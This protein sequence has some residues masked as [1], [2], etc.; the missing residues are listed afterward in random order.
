MKKLLL[1]SLLLCSILS[2][3]SQTVKRSND[4][5]PQVTEKFYVQKANKKIREGEYTASYNK[6]GL[7]AQGSYE[8][9]YRTG[10]WEFYNNK[11][12]H[13]QTY[14]YDTNTMT[15]RD[16]TGKKGMKYYFSQDIVKGDTVRNPIPIGGYYFVIVPLVFYHPELSDMIRKTYPNIEKVECT[17]ILTISPEGLLAKHQ[18]MITVNGK[19]QFYNLSDLN[20]EDEYKKFV[21]GMINGKPV[22]SKITTTTLLSFFGNMVYR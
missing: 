5:T 16:T 6:G 4:L 15:F 14:N 18:V 8:N 7:L 20:L 1:F 22:E 12:D 11:G 21:P 9:G 3:Y 2:G 19:N 13:I 10:E 17:H